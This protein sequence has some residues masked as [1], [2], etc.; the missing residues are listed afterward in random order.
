MP[1]HNADAHYLD[2]ESTRELAMGAHV[3]HQSVRCAD[4]DDQRSKRM[5]IF[6]VIE[7][8]ERPLDRLPR[9]WV[10]MCMTSVSSAQHP[11]P[12]TGPQL[13]SRLSAR[14]NHKVDHYTHP[15]PPFLHPHPHATKS[16][17]TK[18][19]AGLAGGVLGSRV[20][21]FVSEEGGGSDDQ[22]ASKG[23]RSCVEEGGKRK[24]AEESTVRGKEDDIAAWS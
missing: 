2:L 18:G 15:P 19:C 16:S 13:V 24:G 14:P 7:L 8:A 5:E 1:D 9:L 11:V 12:L 10:H 17:T 3:P 6:Q 21:H 22:A 23:E 4:I 20:G